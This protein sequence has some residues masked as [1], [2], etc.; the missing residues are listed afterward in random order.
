MTTERE[1][2]D[3]DPREVEL[4]PAQAEIPDT[5]VQE[6]HGEDRRHMRPHLPRGPFRPVTDLGQET[7]VEESELGTNRS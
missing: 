7:T 4:K 6:T 5:P 2:P 3:L 1:E